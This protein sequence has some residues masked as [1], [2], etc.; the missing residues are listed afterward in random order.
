MGEAVGVGREVGDGGK[1]ALDEVA[2]AARTEAA[3]WFEVA[4]VV[5]RVHIPDLGGGT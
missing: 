1:V 5:E 2:V 4:A 3:A